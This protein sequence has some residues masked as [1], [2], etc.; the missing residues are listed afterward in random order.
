MILALGA[1]EVF[2]AAAPGAV[3]SRVWTTPLN[4]VEE[5]LDTGDPAA[6]LTWWREAQTAA[7]RSG[8]WEAMVEVGDASKRFHDGTA[9]ASRAYLTALLRAQRQQSLDGVL[10]VAT[11]FGEL[12]DRDVL[13]QALRIA[14]REAGSDP[15]ARARVQ[16]VADRWLHRPL[17]TERRDSRIPGGLQP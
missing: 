10:R 12:G 8:Q 3:A 11:A 6:A 4:R 7:L 16:T 14:E 5:A 1:V 17:R 13:A 2:T 9:R 15:R